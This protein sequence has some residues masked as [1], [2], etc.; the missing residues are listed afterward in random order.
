MVVSK[1]CGTT[2]TSLRVAVM[3]LPFSTVNA[4]VFICCV[5]PSAFQAE[6][7]TDFYF[8]AACLAMVHGMIAKHN[9]V[10][11]PM[12][13]GAKR[14]SIADIESQILPISERL[15]VM[16][17]YLLSASATHALTPVADEDGYSPFAILY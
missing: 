3:P 9:T 7:G 16:R 1:L 6:P 12:A 14:D 13:F 8:L 17:V 2:P 11:F 15:N 4:P 5:F 10:F